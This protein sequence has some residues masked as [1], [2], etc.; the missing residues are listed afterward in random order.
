MAYKKK[1]SSPNTSGVLSPISGAAS[2]N[3]NDDG[4]TNTNDF[5]FSNYQ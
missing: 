3:W 2:G 1:F 4:V 5:A